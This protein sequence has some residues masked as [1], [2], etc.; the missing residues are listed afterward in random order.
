MKI[1]HLFSILI[2]LGTTAWQ[3]EAQILDTFNP[4][5]NG[6]VNA[7][8]VQADGEIL[9]GGAFTTLGGQ[10]RNR[11]ARLNADGTLDLG[12]NPGANNNVNALLVQPDGQILLG[13]SFTTMGGQVHTNI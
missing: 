9:V 3:A 4:G 5:A 1:Q 11:L 6:T 10:T 8:A 2:V 7:L 13:G 12:F